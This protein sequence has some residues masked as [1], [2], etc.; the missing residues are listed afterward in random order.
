VEMQESNSREV[1]CATDRKA[2]VNHEPGAASALVLVL[3][4][5]LHQISVE[6]P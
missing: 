6:K 3:Q 5:A 1:S 2:S 4:S